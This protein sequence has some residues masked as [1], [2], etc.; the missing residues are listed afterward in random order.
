MCF[1]PAASAQ[2]CKSAAAAAINAAIGGLT[3]GTARAVAHDSFWK[4]F[5]RGAAGG[6]AQFAGKR[7]IAEGR[8][9]FWLV[10]R[11]VAAVGSSEVANAAQGRRLFQL[12][13]LP[14]GPIRIHLEPRARRVKAPT[15]DLAAAVSALLIAARPGNHFALQESL[16]TGSLVFM[17]PEVS[18][19]VGGNEAGAITLSEL[20]P[21][22]VFIGLDSKRSI[23]SHEMIH[24]AQ[25]DFIVT[26][27]SDALQAAIVRKLHWSSPVTRYVDF[28]LLLPVQY[29]ANG[30]IPYD[31]R[32]WEQE[33]RVLVSNDK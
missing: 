31:S 8:P 6:L 17:A 29:A 24:S 23:I 22:G 33:A 20:A 4:G 3:A 2:C 30:L 16:A 15:L 12:V 11:Q 19:A 28:N 13:T 10:G 1:A 7:I 25:Y 21:D 27:W 9:A 14:V 26:A 5:G 32:P 18:D